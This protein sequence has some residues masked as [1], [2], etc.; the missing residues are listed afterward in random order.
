MEDRMTPAEYAAWTEKRKLGR[1]GYLLRH[2]LLTKG[3]GFAVFMTLVQIIYVR[4]GHG[5]MSPAEGALRF[6]A[7]ACLY[8]GINGWLDWSAEEDRYAQGPESDELEPEIV[9]LKCEALIPA[10]E[11][12]CPAC[13]WSFDDEKGLSEATGGDT[14]AHCDSDE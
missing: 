5:S 11:H 9:C 4:M 2:G 10:N 13:G 3:I 12:R 6:V 7:Y 1:Y 8:G 14:Q